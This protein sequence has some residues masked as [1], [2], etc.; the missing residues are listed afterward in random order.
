[1][2]TTQ[3]GDNLSIYSTECDD[4]EMSNSPNSNSDN[5]SEPRKVPFNEE[6]QPRKV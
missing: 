5:S 3:L 1:M 4:T 2:D 6:Q